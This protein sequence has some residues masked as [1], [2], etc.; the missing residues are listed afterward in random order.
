VGGYRDYL[1]AKDQ[2]Y[3]ADAMTKL[4]PRFG[5]GLREERA[6]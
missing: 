5:Y 4:D 1:S 6:R 2:A 3:A